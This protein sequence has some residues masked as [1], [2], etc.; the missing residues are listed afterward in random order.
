M[1]LSLLLLLTPADADA[2]IN[3][4]D[5]FLRSAKTL[6]VRVEAT[7]SGKL[8]KGVG[9]FTFRAPSEV[10]FKMKWGSEVYTY[11]GGAKGGLELEADSRAYDESIYSKASTGPLCRIS[12]IAT[13]GYPA[14][15]LPGS[16]KRFLPEAG[17]KKVLGNEQIAGEPTDHLQISADGPSGKLEIDMWVRKDGALVKYGLSVASLGRTSKSSIVFTDYGVD[18]PLSAGTFVAAIPR[19]YMPHAFEDIPKPIEPGEVVPVTGWVDAVTGKPAD[20]AKGPSGKRLLVVVAANCKPSAR[21]I[22]AVRELSSSVPVWV[23]N[24]TKTPS[25]AW[26]QSGLRLCH[27]PTGKNL[28]KLSA[29]GTPFFILIDAKGVVQRLWYGFE[30]NAAQAFKKD[31]LLEAGK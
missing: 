27:D 22:D 11:W 9:S 18:K 10:A 4:C 29:P 14:M 17:T 8:G 16:L 25:K 23:L 30:V 7:T 1:L 6:S 2:V 20:L 13:N 12:D 31:V 19:G 5:A 24:T 21:A 3:R 15:L 26:A 28:A